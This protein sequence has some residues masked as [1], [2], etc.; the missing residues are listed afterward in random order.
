MTRSFPLSVH[1]TDQDLLQ[2]HAVRAIS[3]ISG[4]PFLRNMREKGK[5]W[6]ARQ[7]I[8]D[9]AIQKYV[10]PDTPEIHE[11]IEVA[12]EANEKGQAFDRR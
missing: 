4:K 10:G 11:R 9:Q 8:G 5:Y 2:A 6:Y 7:R 12:K 1:V 3:D